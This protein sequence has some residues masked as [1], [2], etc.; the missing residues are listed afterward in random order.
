[1]AFSMAWHAD[2]R[3]GQQPDLFGVADRGRAL[4]RKGGQLADH[5]LSRQRRPQPHFMTCRVPDDRGDDG[6]ARGIERS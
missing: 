3:W 4:A 6:N 5:P 2:A 1:V